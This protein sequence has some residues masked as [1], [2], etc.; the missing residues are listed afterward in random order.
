[1][2]KESGRVAVVIGVLTAAI[3]TF[4]LFQAVTYLFVVPLVLGIV[5]ILLGT[6]TIRSD[7][8]FGE[9]VGW[10]AF[11]LMLTAV[12]IP[13]GLIAYEDRPGPPI[14]LVVPVGHRGPV[15]LIINWQH[16][17][18]IPLKDGKYIY[19]VPESGKLLIKDGSPFRLWHSMTAKYSDG[20]SIPIDYE[21]DLPN[22]TVTLHSFGSGST[23]LGD[24]RDD[25]F[26]G[27]NSEF[28]KYV[29][30]L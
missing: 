21:R 8:E 20:K 25:Y 17:V 11:V 1:M 12:F 18:D 7:G 15:T 29:D 27:T 13:F 24:K 28:R 26:V 6:A 23:T 14:V 19:H 22:D 10:I 30:G 9:Y 2:Y 16:G 4:V 3:P 5:C